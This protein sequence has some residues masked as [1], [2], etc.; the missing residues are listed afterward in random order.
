L[1]DNTL[2]RK[3]PKLRFISP[4]CQC[5]QLFELICLFLLL[6]G[7]LGQV[8][9][10][11]NDLPRPCRY[12]GQANGTVPV[13]I[14]S[15]RVS[16]GYNVLAKHL[17]DVEYIELWYAQG[18]KGPWQFYGFDDDKVTPVHF[19]APSEG[20]YRMLVVVVDR[21]GRRSCQRVNSGG[22]LSKSVEI[23]AETPAQQVMF[24]DYT[25]PEL[26]LQVSLGQEQTQD[27]DAGILEIGWIGFDSHLPE[28]PVELYWQGENHSKHSGEVKQWNKIGKRHGGVGKMN[29]R[30]PD[31]LAGPIV[32]KAVIADA[33][34]N[35]EA[36]YSSP[37]N[38]VYEKDNAKVK[39]N[40]RNKKES[41][42]RLSQPLAVPD[43]GDIVSSITVESA[44]KSGSSRVG[45]SG[46]TAYIQP[47]QEVTPQKTGSV[48]S[49]NDSTGGKI[50]QS[51]RLRGKKLDRFE[52]GGEKMDVDSRNYF[53]R[54]LMHKQ[55]SEWSKAERAFREVLAVDPD[56]LTAKVHLAD[57]SFQKGDYRQARRQYQECLEIKSS[58]KSAL[59][60]LAQTQIAL[61][62]LEEAQQT[63][64]RLMALERKDWKSLLK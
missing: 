32:I 34:G 50:S 58:L 43:A 63:H 1:K 9:A 6:I 64:D 41:G 30:L 47:E 15:K 62:E 7:A 3:L 44:D 51:D 18:E 45:Q 42:D 27:C 38:I 37:I 46:A 28:E 26:Y 17:K 23:P 56:C 52:S 25:K 57:I 48:L 49:A 19:V 35:S 8:K 4:I 14:G 29:W 13:V 10:A 39:L 60:G 16:I 11:D 5:G 55:R 2:R 61:N 31:D 24:I 12:S 36:K 53:R 20:I 33:V 40:A 54:A 22:G 59:F 21:W